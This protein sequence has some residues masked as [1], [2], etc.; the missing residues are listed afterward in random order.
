MI[1]YVGKLE[2]FV[3]PAEFI[4]KHGVGIGGVVQKAVDSAVIRYSSPYVPFQDGILDGS[5]SANT[6]IGSGEIVYATPYARYLWY[7]EKYG[8]NIPIIE[9]GVVVGFW[10]PKEKHPTGEKLNYDTSKH[11]L[12]GPFWC[13]RAMADHKYDVREEAQNA[14]NR[15]GDP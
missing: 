10:S 7:G 14:A 9:N 3:L 5:A 15:T 2:D 1:T 8:P 13:I 11:P 6:V 12:A 4:E